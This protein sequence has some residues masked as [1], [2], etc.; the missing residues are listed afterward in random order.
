[1]KKFSVLMLALVFAFLFT[2]PP[3]QPTPKTSPHSKKPHNKET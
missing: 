1:M 3:P 2:L